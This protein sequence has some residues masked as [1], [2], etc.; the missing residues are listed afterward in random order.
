MLKF[1]VF[2]LLAAAAFLSIRT[3]AADV[4]TLR[5]NVINYMTG[6]GA[7]TNDPVVAQALT[8][9]ENSARNY[10][11]DC[12]PRG[13]WPDIDYTISLAYGGEWQAISQYLR[14]K[15]MGLAYT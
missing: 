2:L 9:L 4:D 11:N 12:Q 14:M 13:G 3:E 7:D 8:D 15:Q 1:S 6:A 5:A 10:M